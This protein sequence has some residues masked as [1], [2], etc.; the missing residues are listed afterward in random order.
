MNKSGVLVLAVT[1][2]CLFAAANVIIGIEKYNKG[3]FKDIVVFVE[4]VNTLDLKEKAAL[5]HLSE[6]TRILVRNA[7]VFLKHIDI[8]NPDIRNFVDKYTV[9]PFVKLFIPMLFS[10][11]SITGNQNYDFGMWLDSD[12]CVN[13]S[14]SSL[15]SFDG[16]KCCWGKPAKALLN[17]PEWFP[18][19]NERDIKPNGGMIVFDREFSDKI[20]D[21]GSQYICKLQKILSLLIKDGVLGIEEFAITLLCKEYEEILNIVPQEYN[22][23][24]PFS[25]GLTPRIAHALG[26]NYKFWNSELVNSA[27]PEWNRNNSIWLNALIQSGVKVEDLFKYNHCKV[28]N[29]CLIKL[30]QKNDWSDFW[31]KTCTELKFSHPALYLDS[32]TCYNYMRFYYKNSES[33]RSYCEINTANKRTFTVSLVITHCQDARVMVCLK[34]IAEDFNFIFAIN[35]NGYSLSSQNVPKRDVSAK[36][37]FIINKTLD[38]CESVH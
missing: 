37:S 16:V 11:N 8:S 27:F 31:I 19:I 26:K 4:N 24:P 12:T 33:Q 34:K 5:I 32:R 21:S 17:H 3:L 25:K 35:D 6:Q 22:F 28:G 20:S 15:F 9:M 7:D 2:D 18:E 36:L 23:H 10:D 29:D 1:N 30:I 13:A 38:L 14:I